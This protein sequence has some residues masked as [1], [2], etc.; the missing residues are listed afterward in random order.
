[1]ASGSRGARKN[2]RKIEPVEPEAARLSAAVPRTGPHVVRIE[3]VLIV[4]LLLLRIAENVVGFLELLEAVLGC[5]IAGI[6]VGMIFAG[7]AAIG[8]PD[9]LDT[10]V[11]S[12]TEDIVIILFRR[13]AA[14]A[15]L[16]LAPGLFLLV[17]H[18]DKLGVDDVVFFLLFL[19][20]AVV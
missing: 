17:V 4:H 10:G 8:F 7:Q 5:F 20:G 9:V 19:A 1:M 16:N 3:P 14:L 11:A 12:Y 2:V 13:H 15:E 18:V 6:E